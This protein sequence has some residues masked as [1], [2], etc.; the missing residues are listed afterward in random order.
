[1]QWLSLVLIQNDEREKIEENEEVG[2]MDE[3]IEKLTYFMKC[4]EF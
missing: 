4:I 2:T 3:L 1:M